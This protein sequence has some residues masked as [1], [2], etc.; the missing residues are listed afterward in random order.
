[1]KTVKLLYT[2]AGWMLEWQ[3]RA[4]LE[5]YEFVEELQRSQ[6]NVLADIL[7]ALNKDNPVAALAYMKVLSDPNGPAYFVAPEVDNATLRSEVWYRSEPNL[8]TQTGVAACG[9]LIEGRDV[10][11]HFENG[12]IV[13]VNKGDENKPHVRHQMVQRHGEV[14][15][16]LEIPETHSLFDT[17]YVIGP[18]LRQGGYPKIDTRP[19]SIREWYALQPKSA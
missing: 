11:I 16:S 13:V 15:T 5:V 8:L 17:L 1:M 6:Q 4:P 2:S 14:I 9:G 12:R 10:M 19:I 3:G 7:L 18:R